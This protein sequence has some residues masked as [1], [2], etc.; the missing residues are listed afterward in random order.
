VL[1]FD[2]M[3]MVNQS[4]GYQKADV[5]I[6]GGG[7]GG[8]CAAIAAARNGAD[9]LL[10]ERCGFLGGLFTGGNMILCHWGAR[11]FWGGLNKEIF[12]RLRDLSAAKFH[13]DDP[14]NYPLYHMRHRVCLS[15]AYDPEVAKLVLF[16]L[17]EDAGVRL[18]LHSYVT[19]AVTEGNIVRGVMVENK[20]GQQFIEGTIVCDGTGDGDVAA[21]AGVPFQKGLGEDHQLFAMTMLVRLSRVDWN[22]VTK[23]SIQDPAWEQ[24]IHTAK[25]TGDL[26]FYS[27]CSIESIPYWGHPH[28]ELGRLWYEDGALLWGGTVEGVDGTDVESLTSAE[29]ACRKQWMSEL[30]FLRKYIPGFVSA[31][32]EH[33]GTSIGVRET[34]HIEGEYQFTGYDILEEHAFPDTVAY[35]VPLFQ[36]VPY[37]CLVPKHAENLLLASKCLSTTPG[38][39]VSGPT[40]GAYND[41]KSIS[42]VMTYGQAAGTAAALCISKNVSPREV[43][44]TLLQKTLRS[45]GAL[46][47]TEMITTLKNTRLPFGKTIAELLQTRLQRARQRWERMGYQFSTPTHGDIERDPVPGLFEH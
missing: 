1:K 19:G 41:M 14:P 12:T 4:I 9:V 31:R 38:Q 15:V 45:Q 44:V 40:L 24:A 7:T 33:S 22:Q 21:S 8:V 16:Q 36:G 47:S 28:P 30:N 10:I 43:D 34:R 29:V 5:V 37:R 18:L 20:S 17:V 46:V 23:Y 42:T 11:Q 13:P 3:N 39:A 25:A 26:P 35:I 27:S 2:V 6:A 32:V